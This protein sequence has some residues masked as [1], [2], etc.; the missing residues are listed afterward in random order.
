MRNNIINDRGLYDNS[1]GVISQPSAVTPW[2]RRSPAHLRDMHTSS[3]AGECIRNIFTYFKIFPD[4][5]RR[6]TWTGDSRESELS[7]NKLYHCS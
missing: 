5:S 4:S 6:N 1:R 3:R 7:S 2:L